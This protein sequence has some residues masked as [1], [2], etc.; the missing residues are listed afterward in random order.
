MT[1]EKPKGWNLSGRG[2]R[3]GCA[4]ATNCVSVAIRQRYA[5]DACWLL[6]AS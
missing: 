1:P 5:V 6:D 3:A 4:P 2:C